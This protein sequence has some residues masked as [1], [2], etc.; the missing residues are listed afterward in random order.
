MTL[1]APQVHGFF[2]MPTDHLTAR[3]ALVDYFRQQDLSDTV[4]VSPDAGHTAPASR[5]ADHLELPLAAG[6]KE[7]LSD[8]SVRITGMIGNVQG[9]R[10]AIIFD[11][12]IAAGSSM[13]E[14]G[15]VL[16]DRG[17]QELNAV[18]THGVFSAN[19]IERLHSL[20][21]MKAIV[22]T[23]TIPLPPAKRTPD[24][25]VISVAPLFG[26]ALKCN[27]LSRGI[28]D[29]FAFWKDFKKDEK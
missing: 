22:T 6:S 27:Y 11:D 16:V 3:P 1:H 7:R 13:V 9:F 5:F 23:D 20:P 8:S 21:Q 28:G 10:R 29:L 2:D 4:V 24:L 25:H 15:K 12:E 14:I 17:I 18:C 26:E 19:A